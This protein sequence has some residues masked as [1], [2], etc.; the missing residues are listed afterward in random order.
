MDGDRSKIVS[1]Y[2]YLENKSKK[3]EL[4]IYLPGDV[5]YAGLEEKFGNEIPVSSF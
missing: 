2:A 5:Y 4:L 1:V 3:N